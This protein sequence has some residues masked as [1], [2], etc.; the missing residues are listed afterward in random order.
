MVGA[1]GADY[2]GLLLVRK[3]VQRAKADKGCGLSG[4]LH[5]FFCQKRGANR[6]HNAWVGRSVDFLSGVLFH[7]AQDGVVLEGAALHY[8][9]FAQRVNV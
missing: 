9:F 3:I 6:S 5:F 4:L 2:V 7:R 8:D 1:E